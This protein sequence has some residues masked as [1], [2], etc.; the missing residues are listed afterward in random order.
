VGPWN[1]CR[2]SERNR[3]KRVAKLL[4]TQCWPRAPD[5]LPPDS[6]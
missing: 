4:S 6:R 5:S 1:K 3:L 2:R